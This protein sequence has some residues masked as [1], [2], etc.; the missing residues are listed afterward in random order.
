MK[1]KQWKIK[2]V[3]RQ[4][5]EI[6]KVKN[7]IYLVNSPANKNYRSA[8][9]YD[10]A[11]KDDVKD[12]GQQEQGKLRH[13]T[14][15]DDSKANNVNIWEFMNEIKNGILGLEIDL[16]LNYGDTSSTGSENDT[17]SD[18]ENDNTNILNF[19]SD[20]I[21]S[22]RTRQVRTATTVTHHGHN[23]NGNSKALKAN[24]DNATLDN[25]TDTS[26]RNNGTGKDRDADA[27]K[28]LGIKEF[29]TTRKQEKKD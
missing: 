17:D 11:Y 14:D 23:R 3:S 28:Y 13:L 18:K 25:N 27:M 19:T 21:H 20:F 4:K 12:Y 5:N 29:N 1:G 24:G 15:N 22:S 7:K 6:N 2:T 8:I 9:V 26:A 10:N 16:N